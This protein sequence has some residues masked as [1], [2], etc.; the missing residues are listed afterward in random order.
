MDRNSFPNGVPQTGQDFGFESKAR[1][2]DHQR[3]QIDAFQVGVLYG[4][5]CTQVGDNIQVAAGAGYTGDQDAGDQIADDTVGDLSAYGSYVK[6]TITNTVVP[7]GDWVE[8]ETY[9]ICIALNEVALV[10]RPDDEGDLQTVRTDNSHQA[11]TAEVILV[12]D[13]AALADADKH[14]RLRVAEIY[15]VS[16]PL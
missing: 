11:A 1:I 13:Y 14:K 8:H 5:E 6:T 4:F 3:A 7:A 10:Q 15:C 9:Y 12:S 2:E 16:N